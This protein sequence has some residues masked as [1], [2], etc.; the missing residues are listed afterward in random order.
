MADLLSL[1]YLDIAA[2]ASDIMIPDDVRDN[3]DACYSLLAAFVNANPS[4]RKS[5]EMYVYEPLTPTD[6]EIDGDWTPPHAKLTADGLPLVVLV[7]QGI[8]ALILDDRTDPHLAVAMPHNGPGHDQRERYLVDMA[9]RVT[10]GD[11]VVIGKRAQ[12]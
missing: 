8:G 11:L 7:F 6:A 5:L 10:K 1:A 3:D 12:A 2:H 4:V 9:R